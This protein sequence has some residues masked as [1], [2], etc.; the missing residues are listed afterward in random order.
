M[1]TPEV[2][3]YEVST[4]IRLVVMATD[5]VGYGYTTVRVNLTDIND[6]APKFG[7]DRYT[8]SVWEGNSR[9]T[10]VTLVSA[11][12][13]DT[14]E[15]G[16]VDYYI[17][18]GNTQ[19]AFAIDPPNTGIV[20]TNIMLDREIIIRDYRLIIEA[21]D[22]GNPPQSSRAVLKINIID[23]NDNAP[24]FPEYST[25]SIREGMCLKEYL[26]TKSANFPVVLKVQQLLRLTKFKCAYISP[27]SSVRH[28]CFFNI[29]C[30]FYLFIEIYQDIDVGTCKLNNHKLTH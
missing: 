20:K 10:Y 9:G 29:L 8:S 5:G 3:D 6:N 23:I 15:N 18:E 16:M 7:Q 13:L 17:V 26:F 24:F 27:I 21:I 19:V 14:G 25:R 11:T 22:Y 30:N 1:Q 28:I 12:D 4:S 2:L